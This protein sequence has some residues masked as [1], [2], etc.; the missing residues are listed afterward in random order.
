[1]SVDPGFVDRHWD[2]FW[3]K[4]DSP[5]RG[6]GDA[7]YAPKTDFWGRTRPA[8]QAPD[9]GALAYSAYWADNRAIPGRPDGHNWPY[10]FA[11][12]P[13]VGMEM[14]DLWFLP[15]DEK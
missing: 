2:C 12:L 1:M 13:G 15:K 11:P 5:A 4:A 3:L 10:R 14:P 6:K 9:L 8:D 7:Q